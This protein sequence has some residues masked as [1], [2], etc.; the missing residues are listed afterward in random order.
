MT[1]LGNALSINMLPIGFKGLLR[2]EEVSL[3]EAK[4]LLQEEGFMSAVGHESTARLLT[5]LLG[6]DVPFSRT[7]VTLEKGVRLIVSQYRGPRL[8][9][10]ATELPPGAS[11]TFYLVEIAG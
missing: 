1:I 7:N 4:A 3:E 2:I 6:L 10:G 8:E 11:I 9:E 5:S